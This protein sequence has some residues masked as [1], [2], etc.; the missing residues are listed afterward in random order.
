MPGV[1]YD[2]IRAQVSIEDV[3]RLLQFTPCESRG[4]RL[5]GLCPVHGSTSPKSRSFSVH[6]GRN[7]YRCFTCGSSGNQLD[8]WAAATKCELHEAAVTLCE[9]MGIEVP[10]IRR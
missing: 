7:I 4:D 2:A 3:L 1:D 8:L 9:R 10:W 5:R 6:L